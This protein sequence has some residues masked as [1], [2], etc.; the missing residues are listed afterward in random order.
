MRSGRGP[1][2]RDQR[3]A[4]SYAAIASRGVLLLLSLLLLLF[5][6]P[7]AVAGKV[8]GS[9]TGYASA[10]KKETTIS[11]VKYICDAFTRSRWCCDPGAVPSGCGWDR[12]SKYENCTRAITTPA[13]PRK[14]TPKGRAQ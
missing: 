9:W 11:G 5:A 1:E 13:K 7:V 14:V 10:G 6:M 12:Q 4:C 8:C 2:R 3:K